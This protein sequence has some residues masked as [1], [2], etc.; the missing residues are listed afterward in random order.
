VP[1]RG[2][3]IL[4]TISQPWFLTSQRARRRVVA[5]RRAWHRDYA[6]P[7]RR[8]YF[9][10]AGVSILAHFV[11]LGVL[12]VSEFAPQKPHRRDEIQ[13][14]RGVSIELVQPPRPAPARPPEEIGKPREPE[15]TKP[16]GVTPVPPK[17]KKTV[18]EQKP[19][20]PKAKQK[21]VPPAPG[22]RPV[23]KTTERTPATVRPVP[24]IPGAKS[25][26]VASQPGISGAH[27]AVEIDVAFPFAA[28]T[29]Q[30]AQKLHR[31]WNP[32]P[33]VPEGTDVVILFAIQRDGRVAGIGVDTSSGH[34]AY[35]ASALSA[36]RAVGSFS[37]L[38]EGFP[39]ERLNVKFHFKFEQG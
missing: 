20:P 25:G 21:P 37:P 11:F 39:G 18:A 4:P 23:G 28:Y 31:L 12:I 30:I 22:S 36:V 26:P 2:R 19:Q 16:D 15:K 9:T 24:A 34:P 1:R 33:G 5:H 3:A 10:A 8:L 35:D 6:R 38:P 7:D 32:A 13:L 27:E 14:A 17:P 29:N